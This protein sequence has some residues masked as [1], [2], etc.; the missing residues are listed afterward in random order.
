MLAAFDGNSHSPVRTHI[1]IEFEDDVY[2]TLTPLCNY[3]DFVRT[4]KLWHTLY[5]CCLIVFLSA[6]AETFRQYLP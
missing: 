3:P 4:D 2:C 6:T 1:D 5:L